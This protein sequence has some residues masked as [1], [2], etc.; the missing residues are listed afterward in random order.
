MPRDK[1]TGKRPLTTRNER[2]KIIELHAEGK[3]YRQIANELGISKDGARKVINYWTDTGELNPPPRPGKKPAL[4]ERDRRYLVRLSDL[5]PRA[6]IAEIAQ[7]AGLKVNPRTI[8][9]YL[10]Q[11]YRLVFLARRKPWLGREGRKRRKR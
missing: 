9:K 7:E 4:N 10:R 11:D 2:V 6:T 5:H 1:A 3:S 8:G